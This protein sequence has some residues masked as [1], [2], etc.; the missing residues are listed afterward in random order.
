MV[1]RTGALLEIT[2]VFLGGPEA[3]QERS[4][5][6]FQGSGSLPGTIFGAQNRFKNDMEAK[7]AQKPAPGVQKPLPER[8]WRASGAEQKNFGNFQKRPRGILERF[9]KNNFPGGAPPRYSRTAG[10]G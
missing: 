4:G 6:D 5:S 2:K 10:E 8:S 7:S 9:F 3:L 1:N